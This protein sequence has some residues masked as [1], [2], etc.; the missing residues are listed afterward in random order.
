MAIE[1]SRR[2]WRAHIPL[3]LYP[4]RSAS[5]NRGGIQEA[6]R[7][8]AKTRFAYLMLLD[9]RCIASNHYGECGLNHR[10]KWSW[11]VGALVQE[12]GCDPESITIIEMNENE[13]RDLI[14]INGDPVA[15]LINE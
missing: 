11:I 6:M 3:L 15:Y 12:F 7:A 10:N 5:T 13:P 1:L 2:G 9:N 14:S 8:Q 4:T